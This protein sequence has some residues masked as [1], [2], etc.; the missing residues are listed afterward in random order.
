[1]NNRIK[2]QNELRLEAD[3][4][5]EYVTAYIKPELGYGNWT[6]GA[7]TVK[8]NRNDVILC[9]NNSENKLYLRVCAYKTIDDN[10]INDFMR[11]VKAECNDK[12]KI[13]WGIITDCD[14]FILINTEVANVQKIP[15][16]I[17]FRISILEKDHWKYMLKYFTYKN[18]F[19]SKNT[20]Y[21][22]EIARF[23]S[24]EILKS[25]NSF[26]TYK[27]TLWNFFDYY[28]DKHTY[29][30]MERYY[31]EPLER[32]PF[33]SFR[34]FITSKREGKSKLL[35]ET[36]I[37]NNYSH[38]AGFFKGLGIQNAEFMKDRDLKIQDFEFATESKTF[39]FLTK[40]NVESII[41][42]FDSDK[43]HSDRNVVL[44]YLLVYM[45]MEK[46]VILDLKWDDIN[47]K[48]GKYI[49]DGF[50]IKLP[51]HFIERFKQLKEQEK[52]NGMTSVFTTLYKGE[53]KNPSA[54]TINCLFKS[55]KESDEKYKDISPL[56][57]RNAL[58]TFLFR[59]GYSLEEICYLMNIKVSNILNYISE[60]EIRTMGAQRLAEDIKKHPFYNIL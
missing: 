51:P 8:S 53:Y 11:T 27:S 21:F 7:P 33:D 4:I 9:D 56:N 36:T 52:K 25:E 48:S 50:N 32:V 49:R 35:K 54:S 26:E 10:N 40:E 47:E 30:E 2:Q 13:E 14:T 41:D 42:L 43:T 34:K 55:L 22:A 15:E 19:Q 31:G 39:S 37:K 29:E 58:A 23:H 12:R 28:S 17:V 59:S 44:F 46:S 20:R 1:M 38:L 18:L 60:E 16:S 5:Q 57:I 45:G 24:K 6:L 3:A